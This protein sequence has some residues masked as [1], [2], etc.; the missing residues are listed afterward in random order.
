MVKVLVIS[1]LGGRIKDL[2]N[3][4][5]KVDLVLAIG[6]SL[7]ASSIPKH[8]NLNLKKITKKSHISKKEQKLCPVLFLQDGPLG[9]FLNFS[10]E[11]ALDLREDRNKAKIHFLGKIGVVKFQNI[12]IAFANAPLSEDSETSVL[13]LDK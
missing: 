6:S 7:D 8:I 2:K 10:G 3:L 13:P 5:K 4:R 12:K 9:S 1:D 11:K